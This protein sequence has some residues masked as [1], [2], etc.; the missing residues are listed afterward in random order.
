MRDFLSDLHCRISSYLYGDNLAA[1]PNN[2]VSLDAATTNITTSGY[3]TLVAS[4]P[5]GTTQIVVVNT[6]SSIVSLAVGKAG[7]EVDLAAVHGGDQISFYVGLNV[8]SQGV[9]LSLRAVDTTASTGYVT[10][11][12]LP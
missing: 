11:S 3:A 9:R 8:L 4:T 2:V 6:T 5:I 10:V 7:S 1:N 12:L